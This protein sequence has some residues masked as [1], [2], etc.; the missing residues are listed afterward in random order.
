MTMKK[1]AIA[2]LVL[3]MIAVVAA[4]GKSDKDETPSTPDTTQTEGGETTAADAE[5]VYQA[6]CIGCHATDLAGGVGP[7]LQKVGGKL[8]QDEIK[9]TITNGRGGMPSFKDKL[10][11]AEI[12][13]LSSWLAG[14]K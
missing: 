10:S 9:T 13:A 7:N 8:S 4:C 12:T 5:K 1:M 11:D 14:H 3:L 6:N 2:A